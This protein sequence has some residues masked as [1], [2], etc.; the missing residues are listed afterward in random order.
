MLSSDK[1]A[2]AEQQQRRRHTQAVAWAVRDATA[3][4]YEEV[5]IEGW[6]PSIVLAGKL[7]HCIGP[8]QPHSVD[9][10]EAAPSFAQLYVHDPAA[11]N[12]EA[13]R[14]YGYMRMDGSASKCD[15]LT[16]AFKGNKKGPR[17]TSEPIC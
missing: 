13:V 7:Y 12:D 9:G 16:K 8:L 15:V 17:A 11:D 5:D 3:E 14:R 10:Q 4:M 2:R 6:A 1:A